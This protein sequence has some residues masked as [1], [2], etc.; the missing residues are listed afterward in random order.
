MQCEFLQ[1]MTTNL[2]ALNKIIIFE[3]YKN[4]DV[5]RKNELNDFVSSSLSLSLLKGGFGHIYTYG[6][7]SHAQ[8]FRLFIRTHEA[9]ATA[10]RQY[11][12]MHEGKKKDQNP[13]LYC[14]YVQR[15]RL[16]VCVCVCVFCRVEFRS[17]RSYRTI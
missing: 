17:L 3:V 13:P 2:F 8:R 7:I 6:S 4:V 12:C 14:L 9:I 1:K 5:A 15:M 10:I 11:K 16:R